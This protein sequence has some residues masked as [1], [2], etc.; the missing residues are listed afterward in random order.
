MREMQTV[1][2]TLSRINPQK[3]CLRDV[4]TGIELWST[5]LSWSTYNIH[6]LLL[7]TV[8]FAVDLGSG[9]LWGKPTVPCCD[10]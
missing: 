4:M 1:N 5:A 2:V 9:L 3:V 8:E 7:L 6:K 10:Q